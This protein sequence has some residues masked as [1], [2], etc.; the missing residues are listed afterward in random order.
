MN[1]GRL[2]P[3]ESS[4]PRRAPGVS[5]GDEEEETCSE[6]STGPQQGE[7]VI[8]EGRGELDGTNEHHGA[9]VHTHCQQGEQ[10]NSHLI[11]HLQHWQRENSVC[12]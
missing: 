9:H 4:H 2:H 1:H 3:L 6:Q 8:D 7:G 10:R 12:N 11:L 5:E